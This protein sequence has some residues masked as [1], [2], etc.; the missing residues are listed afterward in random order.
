MSMHDPP[1]LI[2]TQRRF[3]QSN[4]KRPT[5]ALLESSPSMLRRL[6]SPP[7][8]SPSPP[9]TPTPTFTHLPATPAHGRRKGSGN[10][11]GEGKLLQRRVTLEKTRRLSGL[12]E[13][14]KKEKAK[15]GWWEVYEV[16][17]KVLHSS[18]G[19]VT[20]GLYI[21]RTPVRS[22]IFT[23]FPALVVIGSADI[24][25]LRS[26]SF[27]KIYE[28]VLGPLM[29]ESEKKGP[30][31]VVFYLIGVLAVLSTL[32]LDI[33]TLA[34]LILSWCDTSASVFG[35]LYGR[36]TPKLPFPFGAKK[37]FAGFLGAFAAG[38]LSALLFFPLS[39]F[40]NPSDLSWSSQ[41]LPPRSLPPQ[42]T[43]LPVL[44]RPE[45]NMPLFL[46]ALVCGFAGAIAEGL[47]LAGADDN[48]TIPVLAGGLIWMALRF[49]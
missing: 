40:G 28:R 21:Y 10:S 3:S 19:F 38:A 11:A 31:G 25:R 30:N 9:S 24:L 48:L 34:I 2:S 22:I 41:P 33:A 8:S 17:R 18:I 12:P 14:V 16:P 46:L 37:S 15:N 27:E 13:V 32:P 23:L 20:L 29:R 39:S 7:P 49:W 45:S 36:Y 35:R 4:S 6:S 43:F 47:D 5:S 1:L 42:P 44:P 26:P